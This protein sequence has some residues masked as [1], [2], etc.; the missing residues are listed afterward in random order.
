MILYNIS[1]TLLTQCSTFIIY[2]FCC[3]KCGHSYLRENNLQQLIKTD[4]LSAGE[5][6]RQ[7]ILHKSVHWVD[8]N[9]S[10]EQL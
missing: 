9:L 2:W 3:Q 5:R 7:K 1:G 4:Y 6:Y 8:S 10:W